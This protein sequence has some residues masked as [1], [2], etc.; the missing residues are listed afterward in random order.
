MQIYYKSRTRVVPPTKPKV[1]LSRLFFPLLTLISRE[2]TLKIGLVPI[3]D[4]RVIM[5]MKHSKGKVLDV[6]CGSNIFT[7][8]YKNGIGVDVYPWKGVD[9]IIKNTA[10]L[11]FKKNEFGTVSFLASLNHISN[12]AEALVEARRV[13]KP[14]GV[15]L[16][17][18]ITPHWGK[19]IHWLRY[20]NDPDHKKRDIDHSKE[21]LGISVTDMKILIKNSGFKLEKHKTFVFGLN[22][23]YLARKK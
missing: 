6:G 9:K 20:K 23:F 14:E 17:T 18:M 10:K 5:A 3:D 12:R 16:I 19:F 21:V 1:L 22:H 13:L 4:E 7:K 11:P 15:L 8:S 2:Q